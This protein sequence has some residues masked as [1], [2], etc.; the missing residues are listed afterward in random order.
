M[1]CDERGVEMKK[2]FDYETTCYKDKN[3]QL[4]GKLYLNK[5]LYLDFDENAIYKNSN[6]VNI[7]PGD[8]RFLK[9]IISEHPNHVKRHSLMEEL[10]DNHFLSVEDDDA[11]DKYTKNQ[12][13]RLGNTKWRI[14]KQIGNVIQYKSKEYYVTLP[15]TIKRFDK[16]KKDIYCIKEL[17]PEAYEENNIPVD[18][19]ENTVQEST[20]ISKKFLHSGAKKLFDAST[21][22]ILSELSKLST[23]FNNIST[24][25]NKATPKTDVINDLYQLVVNRCCSDSIKDILKIK[26]PLGSYKNRIMQYLYLA[27]SKNNEDISPFYIDIAFYERIAEF[28][29][30]VSENEIISQ[31]NEDFDNIQKII[32]EDENRIPL[33]FLDGIRDFSRGNESLYYSIK[34]R[35]NDLNCKLVI[36]LDADFTVNKQ[37][38]FNVHPLVSKHFAHYMRIRPMTLHKKE[39]SIEFIKNCMDISSFNFSVD[40]SAEKVYENLI[41]LNFS[42]ID[43]YWLIYI[44]KV[45]SEHFLTMKGNVA[46]L[47]TAI[48]IEVLGNAGLIDSAAELAYEFEFETADTG[49]TNLYYDIRW[50]L[51]R[52]HRSV[53]DFLI[54]KH[55]TSKLLSLNI[56]NENTD[57]NISQLS[58]FNMIIQNNIARFAFALL[59]ED[60]HYEYQVMRV[61]T[62][63]YDNLS[64]IGKSE[65]S[66]RM[67]ALTNSRR[68]QQCIN[69][70]RKYLEAEKVHYQSESAD[71]FEVK[72]DSA[73]LLRSLYINLIYEND[74]SAFV[75]YFNLILSDKL[76]NSINRGFHLEYY[77]DKTF[78][79]NITLLDFEDDVTKG[80]KTFDTLCLILNGR[81]VDCKGMVYASAIELL[82]LCNLI[83]ARIEQN[84]NNNVFDVM[85]Y[86]DSCLRY[87]KWIVKQSPIDEISDVVMY[88]KWI[89]NEFSELLNEATTMDDSKIKY[90]HSSPFN[91]FSIAKGVE[92]AGWLEHQIPNPENIVEHMYNC[93]LI[94]M[95]YLPDEFPKSEYNKNSILQMLLIHDLVE[96]K[97]GNINRPKREENEKEYDIREDNAMQSLF[98]SGTYPNSVDLSTYRAYW[99]LWNKKDGINYLV[100]KDINNIQAIFQFCNY[101]NQYPGNFTIYDVCHWLS[102]I[103]KI[104]SKLGKEI[105]KKLIIN[106]PLYSNIINV[107]NEN[108]DLFIDCKF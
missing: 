14:N 8:F 21:D 27:V 28:N 51:I 60:E 4:G 37:H 71:N 78:I 54:A 81:M 43:A 30:Q 94:G 96:A 66:F 70:I 63:Y 18:S 44:L 73:F 5:D 83:Q 32:S 39:E 34:N 72:K 50:R 47:Y 87:L 88:F 65:L 74:K 20:D 85:P 7:T 46:D 62:N 17:F 61:A 48:C 29:V 49:N 95:L 13:S 3:N 92:R 68:K 101:Y 12:I 106:N 64:L 79:P 58:V 93:W 40:I 11:D 89:Q 99:N 9:I 26:G 76:C 108:R 42:N 56:T 55:Y 91:K 57:E 103:N 38:Q 90:Y 75:D 35:I 86:I 31:I 52:K 45:A 16:E 107:F 33:L 82:T 25:D 102:G 67:T 10:F 59:N 104:K 80:K 84:G 97:T 98:F 69:L 105:L 19:T 36:C 77:G 22:V 23:I 53:L 6:K 100:A 15:K 24:V 41:R 2:T 1:D